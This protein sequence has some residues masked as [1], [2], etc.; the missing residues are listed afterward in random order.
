MAQPYSGPRT[1]AFGGSFFS[2][3]PERIAI[4]EDFR[5]DEGLMISSAEQFSRKEVLPVAERLDAQEDGLMPALLRKAADLGFCG[6]DAPEAY[7]GLGLGK[8]LAARILEFLSLNASFSVTIG[9]HS[10]ISQ[11]GIALFGNHDQKKRYLPG[12]VTAETIGAYALTEPN[13]GSDALSATTRAERVPGGYRLNGTKMWI[14]N[15]K[16]AGVFTV[17]AKIDGK[18][19]TGFIVERS[20]PGV[21]VEREEHKLGLKGSSTARL[22]LVD[23]FVPDD[24]VLY[25]P[26]L[27]HHVAF[28][29][30][31]LGR[32]KLSAMSLGPAREMIGQA[33][34]YALDRRQFGAPIASFGLIR[35][36]FSD[37]A[38][39][40]FAA[41]SMIYRTGALID[42]A[43]DAHGS[44]VAGN[45]R[46]CEEY[47]VECSACKVFATEAEAF[48]LDEALQVYGGYGFSEEFPA[49]R[50]YRDA[51]ISRI[52]EG[53]NEI[54]RLFL[55]DRLRR[56]DREGRASLTSVGDSYVSELAGRAMREDV[57]DQVRMGALSD[58]VMLVYAEQS[59]RLRASQSGIPIHQTLSQA[60]TRWVNPF[61][62]VAF[63]T[64][65]GE[66][67]GLPSPPTASIDE[68]SD[69]VYAAGAPL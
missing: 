35:Q 49:A 55:A 36:K 63:Q 45:R 37:M 30:L 54:N 56:R 11:A 38:V 22:V 20:M 44:D 62:A 9:V 6:I 33:A 27:G 48:V 40:Y 65:T 25:E 67:V 32:F 14:S 52:Y 51:R 39:R 28:N 60:V 41:E 58:L 23:V 24:N 42:D 43:F 29:A 7:G 18:E 1:D 59:S 47:S 17:F 13:A 46:A 57:D 53:T 8:N 69:A 34:R 10:G 66:T 26:G 61:A 50:H 16:W 19:F 3:L 5:G 12:L 4:P 15:A 21:R 2:R 31:N 68:L 64:V